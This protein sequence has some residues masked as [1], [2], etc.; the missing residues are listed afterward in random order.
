MI[1]KTVCSLKKSTVYLQQKVLSDLSDQCQEWKYWWIPSEGSATV[2]IIRWNGTWHNLTDPAV[3]SVMCLQREAPQ[4]AN[5][6]M[7]AIKDFADN[8][9]VAFYIGAQMGTFPVPSI[10]MSA[11]FSLFFFLYFFL[12][13]FNINN[14]KTV[15]ASNQISKYGLSQTINHLL[16]HPSISLSYPYP[17]N[18]TMPAVIPKIKLFC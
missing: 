13:F 2:Q 5:Q 6:R 12:S 1:K 15:E 17:W 9:Y 7:N 3:K 18:Q 14:K 11:S 16:V 4:R 8:A 10:L